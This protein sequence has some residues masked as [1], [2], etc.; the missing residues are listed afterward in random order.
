MR[1]IKNIIAREEGTER[2]TRGGMK[3]KIMEQSRIKTL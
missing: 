2:V 3:K 1:E